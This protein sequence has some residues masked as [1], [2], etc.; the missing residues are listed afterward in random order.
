MDGEQE[1]RPRFRV[2]NRHIGAAHAVG[3]GEEG[4]TDGGF[5]RSRP[6]STARTGFGSD[7][8]ARMEISG[9]VLQLALRFRDALQSRPEL[10]PISDFWYAQ[11]ALT[12]GDDIE[13]FLDRAHQLQCYRQEYGIVDTPE[14]GL[15]CLKEFFELCPGYVMAYSYIPEGNYVLAVD[16]AKFDIQLLRQAPLTYFRA[17]YFLTHLY[18]VDLKSI[19]QGGILFF[20]CE[21]YDWHKHLDFA[22]F[23]KTWTE[24]SNV[25]PLN[26]RTIKFFNTGLFMNLVASMSKKF[27]PT[28]IRDRF[29]M[30]CKFEMG[31]LDHL[32]NQP[33]F[34]AAQDRLWLRIQIGLRQRYENEQHFFI[35]NDL[36]ICG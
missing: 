11:Y 36:L 21:G 13:A 20:E 15:Q 5:G 18:F 10:E 14:F 1:R 32:Y 2:Q 31:R 29:E 6:S 8:A 34:E 3:S 7:D 33:N 23:K 25:Y 12:I 4:G 30:G 9:E 26:V 24:L 17:A 16:Q 27:I 35:V 28:R 19:Q 22:H